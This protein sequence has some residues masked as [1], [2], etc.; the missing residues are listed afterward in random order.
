MVLD[1]RM[2]YLI[3]AAGVVIVTLAILVDSFRDK[4]IYLAPVQG[5][6]VLVGVIVALVGGYFLAVRE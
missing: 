4:V 5:I 3:L 2:A 1:K 6:A